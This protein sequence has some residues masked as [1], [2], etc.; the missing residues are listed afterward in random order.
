MISNERQYRISKAQLKKFEEAL[1]AQKQATRPEDIHPK[2]WQAE[3]DAMRSQIK[4]LK[5]DVTM[6]NN[7]KQG[8]VTTTHVASVADIPNAL[9]QARIAQGLTQKDLAEKLG[10]K[11]QQVQQD[12]NVLYETASLRRLVSVAEVLGLRL[13]GE[14][15]LLQHAS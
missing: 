1:E 7:L 14:A 10:V 9:I 11:E 5:R 8:K 6:Y 3:Q 2:L 4:E 12:E 15:T 13:E